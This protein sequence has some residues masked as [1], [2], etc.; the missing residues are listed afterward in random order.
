MKKLCLTICLL[1]GY[2]AHAHAAAHEERSKKRS[3]PTVTERVTVLELAQAEQIEATYTI[4][5]FGARF[6]DRL[7][8]LAD[9]N[10]ATAL[11][12]KTLC[13]IVTQL[14]GRIDALEE[15]L[16]RQQQWQALLEAASESSTNDALS[17]QTDEQYS[18]GHLFSS[19][20]NDTGYE[21]SADEPEID[22][23][24]TPQKSRKRLRELSHTAEPLQLTRQGALMGDAF[25]Q[26]MQKPHTQDKRQRK[27]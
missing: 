25:I 5:L 20:E 18:I 13:T 2:Q 16:K 9:N 22:S 26:E 10:Y 12:T 4:A 21:S 8:Q 19:T 14:S 17:E 15:E 23:L 24:H 6:G 1:L 11:T 3:K 7:Q 27:Q